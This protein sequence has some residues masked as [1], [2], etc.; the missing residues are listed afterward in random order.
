MVSGV[1]SA[2][3]AT[4]LPDFTPAASMA[5]ANA[6]WR[7]SNPALSQ[8]PPAPINAVVVAVQAS[9]STD[10]DAASFADTCPL[11]TSPASLFTRAPC[12]PDY[13]LALLIHP[14]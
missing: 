1:R 8:S 12:L 7:P 14:R 2:A 6:R 9:A 11:P 13:G 4:T 5:P 3:I 10:P